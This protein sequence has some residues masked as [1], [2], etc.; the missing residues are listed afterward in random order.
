MLDERSVELYNPKVVRST[1]GS[2][3][4][5]PIFRDVLLAE[6]ISQAKQNGFEICATGLSGG[7]PLSKGMFSKKSFIVFGNESHGMSSE[8]EK[9]AD[10]VITIPGF[11]K[12]ESLNVATSCAVVLASVR[13]S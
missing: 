5:F 7:E 13:L 2:M 8:L 1:M 4:H 9:L 12:A 3:F 11:G 10:K 6:T